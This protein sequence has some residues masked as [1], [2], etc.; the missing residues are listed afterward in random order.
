MRR[1]PATPRAHWRERCEEVGFAYHSIDGTYWD[2]SACYVFT[3]EEI[4]QLEM[5]T[6]RLHQMCLEACEYI[7]SHN[8]FAE[9]A[10][11]P[12]FH[13]LVA[14]SWRRRDATLFGRFDLAWHGEGEPKLLEY[15]ADTPTSL[16][17][18]SVAQWD[19]MQEVKPG[20]DQFNSL[21]EKLIAA[22]QTIA[23][24]LQGSPLHFACVKD[25]DEDLGNLE[26]LR[27]TAIQAKIATLHVFIEDIGWDARAR[28]FVDLEHRPISALCKLYPWEWLTAES[29]GQHLVSE[30]CR[31]LEPAWKMLLSNKAIL[32]VL[33]EMFPTS[34][35]LLPAF[36]DPARLTG[37]YVRKPILSREGANVALRRNAGAMVTQGTYGQE[38]YIYQSFTPLFQ[39]AGNYAVIGSWIIGDQPAGIGIR[40]DRSAVT[41]NTSRF[42]PHVFM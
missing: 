17:E 20:C 33:W 29:F 18:A 23:P 3:T 15:N 34:P 31:L 40:E 10:I 16:L 27:D 24:V 21:H 9:F 25:S 30:P 13:Q 38:G 41:S 32:A 12:Q 4:D 28:R 39:T 6:A 5:A 8:R 19:W 26:Y 11:P 22:W 35:Y 7:V 36:R 37:D 1:E 14:T 2:E 42:V